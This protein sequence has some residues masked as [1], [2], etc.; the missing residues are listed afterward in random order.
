MNYD[1]TADPRFIPTPLTEAIEEQRQLLEGQLAELEDGLARCEELFRMFDSPAWATL[2]RIVASN[3]DEIERRM[4]KEVDQVRWNLLR[5]QKLWVDWAL[6]L[7]Q[8]IS[9]LRD[10]T[11]RRMRSVQGQMGQDEQGV[12]TDE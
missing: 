3:S 8:E 9:K 10:A 5:G 7:P 2:M 1:P 11:M 12:D 6:G 4:V